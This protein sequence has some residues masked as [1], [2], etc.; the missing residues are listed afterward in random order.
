MSILPWRKAADRIAMR[1]ANIA[2]LE[3]MRDAFKQEAAELKGRDD[4]CSQEIV[5]ALEDKAERVGRAIERNI[6]GA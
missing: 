6:G 3:G 1:E 4:T 2:A 5:Q